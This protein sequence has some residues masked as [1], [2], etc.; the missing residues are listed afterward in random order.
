MAADNKPQRGGVGGN[1][2]KCGMAAV[3]MGPWLRGALFLLAA[4]LAGSFLLVQYRILAEAGQARAE[5]APYLLVLGAGV[6]ADGSLSQILESRLQTALQLA[7]RYPH[8]QLLLS[9]GQGG[10]EPRAE[11]EAMRDYLTGHGLPASR[12]LLES[13]SRD[14]LQNMRLSRQLLS[15][16]GVA[17]PA[18]VLLVTSDFHL[19]RA[20]QLAQANGFVVSEAAAP[21]PWTVYLFYAAR[22]YPA[23]INEWLRA[24]F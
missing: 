3:L 5:A 17:S 15:G 23:L 18:L 16:R 1:V 13:R 21:T 12:L 6:H 20:R 8:A 22:E 19:Y 14:T 24:R 2:A 11:A 10:S 9:G 4:V 7:Q